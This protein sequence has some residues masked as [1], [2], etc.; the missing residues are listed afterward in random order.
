MAGGFDKR[1]K[2]RWVLGSCVVVV[3]V[4]AV[5]MRDVLGGREI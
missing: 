1:K 5:I 3:L 4:G 2:N